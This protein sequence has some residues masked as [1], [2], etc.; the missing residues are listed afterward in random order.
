MSQSRKPW[1]D[2]Q[3]G[4]WHSYFDQHPHSNN[5]TKE[6]LSAAIDPA[7]LA[8]E[9]CHKDWHAPSQFPP[10]VLEW[11]KGQTD[12]AVLLRAGLNYEGY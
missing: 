12:V 5:A 1:L 6:L 2:V 8:I 4:E 3:D 9:S 10:A 11:F 7:I